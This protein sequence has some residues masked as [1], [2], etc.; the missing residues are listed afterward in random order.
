MA[1]TRSN[2]YHYGFSKVDSATTRGAFY[3]PQF[4][5]DDYESSVALNR[6]TARCHIQIRQPFREAIPPPSGYSSTSGLQC[7]AYQKQ[8]LLDDRIASSGLLFSEFQSLPDG[9]RMLE[10]DTIGEVKEEPIGNRFSGFSSNPSKVG[11]MPSPAKGEPQLPHSKSPPLASE[12]HDSEKDWLSF[13]EQH[14]F[15]PKDEPAAWHTAMPHVED[16]MFESL[17]MLLEPRPLEEMLASSLS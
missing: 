2:R 10:T 16:V 5:K 4:R 11:H 3:H 7:H 12:R 1:F 8:L 14:M 9:R 6:K 15:H 13:L 17:S